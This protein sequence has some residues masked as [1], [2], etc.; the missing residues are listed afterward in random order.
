LAIIFTFGLLYNS[1]GKRAE[2]ENARCARF[3]GCAAHHFNGFMGNEDVTRPR[4]DIRL[5]TL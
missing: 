3:F 2:L 4:E 5:D 1:R